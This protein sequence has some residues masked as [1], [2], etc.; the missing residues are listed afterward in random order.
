MDHAETGDFGT[1]DSGTCEKIDTPLTQ[2]RS[3]PV[4]GYVYFIQ[5]AEAIKIGYSKDAPKRLAGLQTSSS[6]D[7]VLLGFV[8]GTRDDERELHK[9]FCH[10]Q[11]RGEWFRLEEELTDYIKSALWEEEEKASRPPPSPEVAA[12]I[13]ALLQKRR[14]CERYSPAWYIYC[15][16]VEQIRNHEYE[17]GERAELL[18]RAM[19][20][21]VAG[22]ARLETQHAVQ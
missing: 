14:K 15:N 11:L 22:L 21:Q 13:R 1:N 8:R 9:M 16:L 17:T 12:T 10:L 7:L 4:R 20:W 18:K 6:E 2:P 19:A 5:A 3:R